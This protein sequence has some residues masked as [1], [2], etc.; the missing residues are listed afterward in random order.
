MIY[1]NEPYE[2]ERIKDRNKNRQAQMKSGKALR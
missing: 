1:S 2:N